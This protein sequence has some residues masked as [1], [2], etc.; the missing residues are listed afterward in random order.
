[1]VHSCVERRLHLKVVPEN[2]PLFG[3]PDM[4]LLARLSHYFDFPVVRQ[5]NKISKR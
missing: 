5:G 2:R 4:L 3:G 1:M